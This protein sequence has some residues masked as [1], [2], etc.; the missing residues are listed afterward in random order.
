MHQIPVD[1]GIGK[2]GQ[3][4]GQ[5][6]Q[7]FLQRLKATEEDSGTMLDHTLSLYGSSNSI[8]GTHGIRNLPLIVSG[9]QGFGF[10][11]GQYLKYNK[12][13]SDMPL[14]NLYATLARQ[15]GLPIETFADSNGH[16]S[17]LLK[18]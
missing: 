4:F 1:D 14:T 10:K 6:R 5:Y 9:G 2:A 13:G 18:S 11:Q 15:F 8:G 12:T 3:L 16:T 17:E 7:Q